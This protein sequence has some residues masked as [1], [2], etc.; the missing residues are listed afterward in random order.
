MG[1]SSVPEVATIDLLAAIIGLPSV[2]AS[3]NL[4]MFAAEKNVV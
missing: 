2:V 4:E 1:H 3:H